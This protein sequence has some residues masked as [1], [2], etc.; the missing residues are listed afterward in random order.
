MGVMGVILNLPNNCVDTFWRYY[1]GDVVVPKRAW[2]YVHRTFFYYDQLLLRIR[3]CNNARRR[4]KTGFRP[5]SQME[6]DRENNP[7]FPYFEAMTES[8][9]VNF[10]DRRN[11][12]K[13]IEPDDEFV[14][15]NS[16]GWRDV[17]RDH[18]KV[19]EMREEILEKNGMK[20]LV[21]CAPSELQRAADLF[22]KDGFVVIRDVLN[23]EQLE[24]LRKGCEEVMTAIVKKDKHRRGNRGSHQY[25]FSAP[26]RH[27]SMLHHPAWVQLVDLPTLTPILQRIFDSP[28]YLCYGAGGDFSLPGTVFSQPLHTAIGDRFVY[29]E[30]GTG[31]LVSHGSFRDPR[32]IMTLR[33]LP[34]PSIACNFFPHDQ[35]VLDGPTRQ[36]R[37]TQHWNG[38]S[39]GLHVEPDLMKYSTVCPVPAGAVILRDVRAWHGGTP[40]ISERVRA[41]PAVYY[42]APWYREIPKGGPAMPRDVYEDK[43]VT[44]EYAR[45][46]LRQVVA[47]PGE[48]VDTSMRDDIGS[49]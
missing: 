19:V 49:Y 15:L 32:G 16:S 3:K 21:I 35:T 11:R 7:R 44:T 5:A 6:M 48:H 46:I 2:W 24:K 47:D 13:K 22:Y 42:H 8:N 17:P 23:A 9:S 38:P 25:T 14:D 36:V 33:D 34:C 20:D 30:P 12:R 27:N 26:F 1:T 4:L 18:P 37:G 45:Y 31:D 10:M 41:I 40:N 43:S 28:D 29:Q 39:P